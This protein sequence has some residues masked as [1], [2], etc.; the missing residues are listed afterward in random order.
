MA[1]TP[2]TF[3]KDKLLKAYSENIYVNATDE[4][5]LMELSGFSIKV[6]NGDERNYKITKKTDWGLAE[7]IA[8]ENKK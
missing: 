3:H 4:S 6:I 8:R 5:N 7:I 2:Q 1:Q